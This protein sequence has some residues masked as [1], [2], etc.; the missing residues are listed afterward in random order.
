MEKIMASDLISE[1]RH[2]AKDFKK[3]AFLSY[4]PKSEAFDLNFGEYVVRANLYGMQGFLDLFWE[5]YMRSQKALLEAVNY[6]HKAAFLSFGE[7]PE[8]CA[9]EHGTSGMVA[10]GKDFE[11]FLFRKAN[12]IPY[13][14]ELDVLKD[15]QFVGTAFVPLDAEGHLAE[16]M[17]PSIGSCNED[18][19]FGRDF[20][21]FALALAN[22][23]AVRIKKEVSLPKGWY[24][25]SDRV[26]RKEYECLTLSFEG[27]VDHAKSPRKRHGAKRARIGHFGD[28]RDGR[29][30]FG[31]WHGIFYFS[32]V[33]V[34]EEE[35]LAD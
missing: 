10:C 16:E 4:L 19:V 22:S 32:A 28:Y 30:L 7:I 25:H 34:D 35:V 33:V 23:D 21:L 14:L 31:K 2:T 1:F 17:I 26:S 29:G 12:W 24:K 8:A 27:F 15:E 3:Q 13:V 18:V 11:D 9:A 5:K 20:S 6:A